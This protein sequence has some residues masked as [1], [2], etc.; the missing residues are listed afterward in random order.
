MT[1][2]F[3]HRFRRGG[4]EPGGQPEE[5]AGGEAGGQVPEEADVLQGRVLCIRKDLF[6]DFTR[7]NSV[8]EIINSGSGMICREFIPNPE[9]YIR[10]QILPPKSFR[11]RP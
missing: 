8:S 2:V 4:V 9:G 6:R 11:I 10:I 1:E 3:L 5:G 7:I